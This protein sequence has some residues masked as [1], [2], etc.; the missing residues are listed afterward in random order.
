[1]PHVFPRSALPLKLGAVGELVPRTRVV[2]V[3]KIFL[4]Q[5]RLR[6]RRLPVRW[7]ICGRLYHHIIIVGQ[8]IGELALECLAFQLGHVS[9]LTAAIAFTLRVSVAVGQWVFV[10]LDSVAGGAA[11]HVRRCQPALDG[12]T[13][14]CG[15]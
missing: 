9:L 15:R 7:D 8:A 4:A 13:C 1:M 12:G 11:G 2:D 3:A 6:R 5:V 14:R 10:H